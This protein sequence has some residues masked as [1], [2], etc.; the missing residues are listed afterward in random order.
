MR[1]AHDPSGFRARRLWHR[2]R[3]QQH[4]GDPRHPRRQRQLAAGDQIEPVGLAPDFH[5]HGAERIA[6][7]R[8][9]RR[10]QRGFHIGRANA[11]Y[12]A[13]IEPE[14]AKTAH[15]QRA[16]FQFGKILPHPQ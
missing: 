12:Q 15:R 11:H 8:I 1:R 5:D 3:A 10:A 16:G 4:A 7:Q 13:R 9:S 14:F 2:R 6:G